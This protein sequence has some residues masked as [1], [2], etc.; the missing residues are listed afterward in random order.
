[1]NIKSR[2]SIQ[3]VVLPRI[4]ANARYKVIKQKVY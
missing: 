2:L 1:M 4:T 3:S